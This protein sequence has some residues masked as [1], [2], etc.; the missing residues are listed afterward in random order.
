MS[1]ELILKLIFIKILSTLPPLVGFVQKVTLL[2]SLH[3]PKVVFHD[4]RVMIE[5]A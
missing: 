1:H 5:D 2:I 3:P 4:E